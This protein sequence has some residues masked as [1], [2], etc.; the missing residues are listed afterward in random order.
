MFNPRFNNVTSLHEG[1]ALTSSCTRRAYARTVFRLPVG[2]QLPLK[3]RLFWHQQARTSS[4]RTPSHGA[5]SLHAVRVNQGAVEVRTRLGHRWTMLAY[6]GC[7]ASIACV[8]QL[9]CVG[10]V[11]AQIGRAKGFD[12]VGAGESAVSFAG[13]GGC[14]MRFYPAGSKPGTEARSSFQSLERSR[15]FTRLE[16]MEGSIWGQNI[17]SV[18]KKSDDDTKRAKEGARSDASSA[19]DSEAVSPARRV[20]VQAVKLESN[21]SASSERHAPQAQ[22][23]THLK[24]SR[25]KVASTSGDAK[26]GSR[27]SAGAAHE[28]DGQDAS[29]AKPN[30]WLLRVERKQ[31]AGRPGSDSSLYGT[32][33]SAQPVSSSKAAAG[34]S[35]GTNKA[36]ANA[37]AGAKT[38]TAKTGTA[39]GAAKKPHWL[40]GKPSVVDGD[41]GAKPAANGTAKAAASASVASKRGDAV[42]AAQGKEDEAKTPSSSRSVWGHAVRGPAVGPDASS[43]KPEDGSWW[44]KQKSDKDATSK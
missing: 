32:V 8:A 38:G 35:S 21:K 42:S 14:A 37:A 27:G 31:P 1:T 4:Q 7:M 18:Q 6:L 16:G 26:H 36:T 30:S 34:K 3:H 2:N 25:G 29:A 11:R 5:P 44:S 10:Q 17:W 24:R 28:R 13:L 40:H 41:E 23:G 15:L 33:K 43:K 20:Q 39:Q 12:A 9:A 22:E 19:K